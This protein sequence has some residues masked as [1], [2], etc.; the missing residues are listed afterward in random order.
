MIARTSERTAYKATTSQSISPKVQLHLLLYIALKDYFDVERLIAVR[1]VSAAVINI[2]G[3]Q[4]MLCQR[5]ALYAL[6]LVAFQETQER[7]RLRAKLLSVVELMEKSH[8]GLL[9]GDSQLS[10]PETHSSA[11][12][13]IYFHSP[14]CLDRKITDFIGAGRAIAGAVEEN[15]KLNNPNLQH[16]IVASESDLLDTLDAVVTQY[17]KEQEEE[18]LAIDLY[19]A[20][21]YQE[22]CTAMAVAQTRS[23][24]LSQTLAELQNTQVQLIQAE[25]LSELGQL[26]AGVAHEI[27]NPLGFIGGNLDY[28]ETYVSD[29]LNLLKLY[30][31]SYPEPTREIQQLSGDIELEFIGEDL[32]KLV[33]SMKMGVKRIQDIVLSLRNFSRA[34]EGKPQIINLHECIQTTLIVLRYRFKHGCQDRGIELIEEFDRIPPVECYSGQLSQALMNI[35]SNAIDALEESNSHPKEEKD[36]K[37]NFNVGN[38]IVRPSKP[39]I[40]IKTKLVRSEDC[41]DAIA[42]CIADNGAGMAEEV[43]QSLFKPFFTTKPV[44]KGTGLGLSISHQIIVER[45]RGS[46]ECRSQLGQGTE[47][48]LTIPL[49]QSFEGLT[50]P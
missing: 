30:E 19:Q 42:I 35:V 23:Q 33:N 28:A 25:K 49:R 20:K 1:E 26:V 5:A 24:E 43:R 3:R 9:A 31:Q 8:R 4:R 46:L 40:W 32:P 27:N 36:E 15:L 48:I 18:E 2:S 39:T 45:H 13:K 11:V 29:L 10:L 37:N 50:T 41:G 14:Y 34:D 38:C 16:L 7:T 21:L 22:T 47:F 17:Q 12:E 44:G 6:R